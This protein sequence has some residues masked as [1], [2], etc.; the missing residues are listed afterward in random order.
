MPSQ[1]E[2]T[3]EGTLLRIISYIADSILPLI[4]AE[5]ELT[6]NHCPQF[7]DLTSNNFPRRTKYFVCE[8]S[9]NS[10]LE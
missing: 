8:A 7:Q 5:P 2:R 6:G 4:P 3:E 9:C 1:R 10:P